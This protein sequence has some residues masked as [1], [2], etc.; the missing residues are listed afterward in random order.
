MSEFERHVDPLVFAEDMCAYEKCKHH[1][2]MNTLRQIKQNE[3]AQ[4][5]A[6]KTRHDQLRRRI[7]QKICDRR[8]VPDAYLDGGVKP[9]QLDFNPADKVPMTTSIPC[10]N[11]LGRVRYC[12]LECLIRHKPKHG[13]TCHKTFQNLKAKIFARRMRQFQSESKGYPN[14][15]QHLV[16]NVNREMLTSNIF[17]IRMPFDTSVKLTVDYP[18][19]RIPHN[20]LGKLVGRSKNSCL[21]ATYEVIMKSMAEALRND[22][23]QVYFVGF[24]P[25]MMMTVTN[26]VPFAEAQRL[27]E[28]NISVQGFTSLCP[29]LLHQGRK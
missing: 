20:E 13:K 11:C 6:A 19:R 1:A 28:A 26:I 21:R 2:D 3:M 29:C 12:S 18:I 24:T 27:R 7:K 10:V 14:L 23:Q 17:F 16:T 15:M 22:I 5:D 8:Y 25:D 4:P 9:A